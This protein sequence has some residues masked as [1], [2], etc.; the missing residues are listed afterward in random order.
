[1]EVAGAAVVLVGHVARVLGRHELEL[2]GQGPRAPVFDAVVGQRPERAA[3]LRRDRHEAVAVRHAHVRQPREADREADGVGDVLDLAVRHRRGPAFRG[4]GRPGLAPLPVHEGRP[5]QPLRHLLRGPR[6]LRVGRLRRARL[7]VPEPL[8]D[9]LRVGL[10][11]QEFREPPRLPLVVLA[12][13]RLGAH[14]L[15]LLALRERRELLVVVDAALAHAPLE[16][17]LPQE[18]PTNLLVGRLALLVEPVPHEAPHLLVAAL[19]V[20]QE[21]VVELRV[22]RRLGLRLARL[23]P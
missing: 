3:A 8:L 6:A 16:A 13:L 22:P 2:Q 23:L 11:P 15:D 21:L 1:M 14:L 9:V 19:H 10:V 5:R 17:L 20:A 18:L 12:L 4:V 7:L